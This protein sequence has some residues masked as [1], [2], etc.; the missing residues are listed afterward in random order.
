MSKKNLWDNSSL[1]QDI[2]WDNQELPGCPDEIL[3]T[4]HWDKVRDIPKLVKDVKWIDEHKKGITQRTNDWLLNV[5]KANKEKYTPEYL[6]K[7]RQR[8][9]ERTASKEWQDKVKA[10][11]A[12]KKKPVMTPDGMFNS[13]VE[14]ANFYKI[15]PARISELM[16]LHPDQYYYIKKDDD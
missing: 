10:N 12:K 11:A 15:W 6:E 13:R 3:L 14:A 9:K 5:Q 1:Q 7:H 2:E 4:K 8:M 16:K